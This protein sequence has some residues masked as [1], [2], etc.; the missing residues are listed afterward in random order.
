MHAYVLMLQTD[1]DDIFITESVLSEIG[2]SI[3]VKF[4]ADMQEMDEWIAVSGKPAVILLNDRGATH[5][6]TEILKKIKSH[7][8]YGHIPVI[9]LGE[10]ST[11][12]YIRQCYLA[13]ANTFI[14]KPSSIAE[15]RKK[16][17]TF[18]EYWFEVADVPAI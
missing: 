9:V 17:S 2:N 15:T 8:A 3:P 7:S 12:E 11:G 13:G 4:I 14:T 1:A 5:T 16:I 6:D 18:F 10:V